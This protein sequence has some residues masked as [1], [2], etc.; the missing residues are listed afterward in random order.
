MHSEATCVDQ[1]SGHQ[2][3]KEFLQ[4]KGLWLI[5]KNKSFDTLQS[6]IYSKAF[7]GIINITN[8]KTVLKSHEKI[9]WSDCVILY[10]Q[11]FL[12]F[13]ESLSIF[14]IISKQWAI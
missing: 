14:W 10:D 8:D 9:V 2:V 4:Y 5:G 13:Q 1:I 11:N 3:P 7:Q 6:H 12:V